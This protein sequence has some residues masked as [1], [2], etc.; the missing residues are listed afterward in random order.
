[1]IFNDTHD[2]TLHG[3]IM[4][5][6]TEKPAGKPQL[7]CSRPNVITYRA[8]DIMAKMLGGETAFIPS[9][10]GFIYAPVG[11][12][13]TNPGSDRAQEWD[14]IAA[15]VNGQNGNMLIC[16]LTA[17]PTY[18][19]DGDAARYSNN[20]VTLASITDLAATIAFPLSGGYETTPPQTGDYYYQ[21]V[22]LSLKYL[23]GSTTPEYIPFARAGLTS[24]TGGI[25]VQSNADFTI[26]W[27]ISFK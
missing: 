25:I 3:H 23:P 1:M 22:L 10:I 8:A 15:D 6:M 16:P 11:K 17:A 4:G 13:F 24:G 2:L 5:Y 20:V 14:T 12:A 18:G 21:V 26:Y 9:H 7:V 19:V 27:T